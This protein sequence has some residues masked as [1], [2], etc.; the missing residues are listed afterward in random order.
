[1]KKL[2]FLLFALL[3]SNAAFCGTYGC[4]N[5]KDYGAAGNNSTDDTVDINAAI[6]AAGAATIVEPNGTITKGGC[7]YFPAGVY[8]VSSTLTFPARVSAVGD[9]PGG[10]WTGSDNSPG[11]SVIRGTMNATIL[12]FPNDRFSVQ[13]LGVSGPANSAD[14]SSE[15]I[16]IGP[17]AV[18]QFF[19]EHVYTEFCY[20]GIYIDGVNNGMLNDVMA[21]ANY[22][23]GIRAM[24]AQGAWHGIN[25]IINGSDGVYFGTPSVNSTANPWITGLQTFGNGGW[26]ANVQ[27]QGLVLSTSFMNNDYSGEI[28]LGSGAANSSIVN[29]QIQYAGRTTVYGTNTTAVGLSIAAGSVEDVALNNLMFFGDEGNDIVANGTSGNLVISNSTFEGAGAGGVANNNYAISSVQPRLS[30]SNI[31]STNPVTFS[32]NYSSWANSFIEANTASQAAF[33]VAGGVNHN[34]SGMQLYQ[35]S[36]GKA[37]TSATGTSY[38]IAATQVYGGSTSHGTLISSFAGSP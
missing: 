35:N 11:A 17:S 38:T 4:F 33:N 26:G 27:T 34:I 20:D 32:G 8:V 29:T 24:G 36:T 14:T 7:V 13:N 12:S 5:V 15:C 16:K 6:T 22:R 2:L 28:N 9:G 1:M 37:F 21:Q 25:L 18:R 23:N 10:I 30:V 31:N 3:F 19:L